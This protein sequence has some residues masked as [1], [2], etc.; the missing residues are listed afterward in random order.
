[1]QRVK[2]RET[3]NRTPILGRYEDSAKFLGSNKTSIR[4]ESRE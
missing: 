4:T 1:M 2:C 3:A